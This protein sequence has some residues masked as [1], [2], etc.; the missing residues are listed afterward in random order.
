MQSLQMRDHRRLAIVARREIDMTAFARHGNLMACTEDERGDAKPRSRADQTDR[1]AGDRHALGADRRKFRRVEPRNGKRQRG[2][3]VHQLRPRGARH[4]AQ[5]TDR[6][7]PETIRHGNMRAGTLAFDGACRTSRDARNTRMARLVEETSERCFKGR[8]VRRPI[9]RWRR[10][11]DAPATLLRQ[12]KARVCATDI[13]DEKR[14]FVR[15][16]HFR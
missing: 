2:E 11:T 5:R 4:L 13:C 10:H 9:D 16:A 6:H 7:V 1:L 12:S 3:V 14:A 8:K 15:P